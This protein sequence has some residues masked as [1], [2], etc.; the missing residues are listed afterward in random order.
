M[1][2]RIIAKGKQVVSS[3]QNTI[4]S[5]ATVIA[6]IF[7]FSAVLGII[8][9]RLLAGYFGDSPELSIYFA[10]DVIPS[11]I[12]TLI[13]SGSL[14]SAFIPVFTQGYKKSHKEGWDITTGVLNVTLVLLL[15]FSV[16]VFIF[17]EFI[18]T[19]LI[20]RNSELTHAQIDLMVQL[21]RIMMI[22][23][24]PLIMSSIFTSILQSFNKFVVSALAPVLYNVGIITFI[25]LF[26]PT[27]GVYAPALGMIFGSLLHMG[28][29][30]PM[31]KN[32]GFKY[33]F[34]MM[35]KN[36]S[37]WKVYKLMI[38]RTIGQAA[39]KMLIPLYTNLAL[40][41]SL[42]SNV[43]F[44]FAYDIQS[45]PVRLFGVSIGQA[46][47]PF[48][49]RSYEADNKTEFKAL[50]IKTIH[51]VIYFVLP[52]SIMI[53]VLRVPIVR[54]TVGSDK[55][56]WEATVMTAYSLAFFSLSLI[57][58]SLIMI[59][60]RSYYA[61]QNT[62]TPLYYSII[63]ISIN[64]VLAIYFVHVLSFGVWSLALAYTIG[65]FINCG[66]LMWGLRKRLGGVDLIA[67]IGPIN[68]ILIASLIMG[69]ALYI[70]LKLMDQLVFDTTRTIWLIV[71]TGIVFI[72]GFFTYI[73][74]S[75][76]F[77]I[78][79]LRMFTIAIRKVKEM[80]VRKPAV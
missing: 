31:V 10:A 26:A 23:Q 80:L 79:E 55:Y 68:K 73:L 59:L 67:F 2:M 17:S 9:N 3:E 38:P 12:F 35:W 65:S 69:V 14:S 46:A 20:G 47:L 56:S 39:Q 43:I 34:Q 30:I 49:S 22:A 63:S 42:P 54:L 58:Q 57:P 72:I 71:L 48:L 27:L 8:R 53:I 60:A 74:L 7:A 4:L 36:R 51:E 13:I 62:K 75:K 28:I 16:L 15:I 45:L 24:V 6:I 37:V 77:K 19:E 66:L 50:L 70:P 41:I 52:V 1:V 33:R 40:Y 18:V 61:M 11:L 5:A 44:T 29:Q 78:E 76:I 21:M 64:A 32:L 25:I